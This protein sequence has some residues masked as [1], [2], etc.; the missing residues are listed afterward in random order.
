MSACLRM[1]G[2]VTVW[3]IV[4]TQ[5]R[6]AGLAGPEMHPA[7]ANLY[8][9]F[10]FATLRMLES[11][12]LSDVRTRFVRHICLE[13]ASQTRHPERSEYLANYPRSKLRG[14]SL[15]SE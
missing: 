13:A 14:F 10:A 8:A 11:C 3:G 12:Y 9:L 1:F 15:R 7:R 4:A 6:I 2:G 5:R